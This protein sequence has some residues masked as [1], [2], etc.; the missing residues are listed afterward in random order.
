MPEL[1]GVSFTG[2]WFSNNEDP[3]AA[4]V[5][6]WGVDKSI[7]VQSRTNIQNRSKTQ[8]FMGAG[9]P[10]GSSGELNVTIKGLPQ[11]GRQAVCSQS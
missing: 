5:S 2:I 7:Q 10:Y 6:G 8:I 9:R 11:A 4:W 1:G 3:E